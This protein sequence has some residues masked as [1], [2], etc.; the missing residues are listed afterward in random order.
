MYLYDLII[1]NR[2][3]LKVFFTVVILTICAII[4]FKTHKLFKFSFH[5][6]IR[7]FRNAFLFYFLAFLT[8]HI[9]TEIYDHG[10]VL[11]ELLSYAFVVKIVY[12][13]F[14]VMAGFFLLFSLFW[15]RFEKKESSVSSLFNLKII[16]FYGLALI[17][18]LL[19]YTWS[20]LYFMF[21]SQIVLFSFAGGACFIKY[22][23]NE[24]AGNF[25]KMYLLVIVLNLA[26][27]TINFIVLSSFHFSLESSSW[28]QIGNIG[29]YSLTIIT[30][31]LFL[32]SVVR[33]T[34]K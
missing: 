34:K 18:A 16:L 32:Y 17:I 30:F 1:A 26:L 7:Y 19:D 29:V 15:K 21:L 25:L 11:V 20:T 23:E 14:L 12:E 3:L 33:A 28:H 24:K 9:L 5:Q 27:W 2:E 22:I 13:F 6:G 8:R 10:A 4:V 31:S